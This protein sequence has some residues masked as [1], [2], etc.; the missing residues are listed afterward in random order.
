[1]EPHSA[2]T[3][4][5]FQ[6]LSSG[7]VDDEFWH[8]LY[9]RKLQVQQLSEEAIH[10]VA[11]I[12]PTARRGL[13]ATLHVEAASLSGDCEVEKGKLKVPGT[14]VNFN[15]AARFASKNAREE[16]FRNVVGRIWEDV[17][18]G[19]ALRD[20]SKLSRFL[21]VTFA[22]LKSF[23]FH[24]WFAFPAIKPPENF[25]A[26]KPVPLPQ[27][28]TVTQE[29]VDSCARRTSEL[30]WALHLTDTSQ[31]VEGS[32]SEFHSL[33]EKFGQVYVAYAD[34]SLDQNTAGWTL[35]NLLILMQRWWVQ[36]RVKV[37]SVRYCRGRPDLNSS[38]VLDIELPQ[39][40][41]NFSAE[42]TPVAVGWEKNRA[43]KLLPR[44]VNLSSSMDPSKLAS[45]AVD[46][47]LR[48]MKWRAAPG[49]DI[50]RVARLNCLILGAGTLGCTVARGLVAWGVRN[51]T[52][53]DAG[54]VS[55]S[56]PARQS[57][58]VFHDCLGGGLPK[59]E[60]A[61]THLKEV[62]PGVL[63]TGVEMTIPMPGHRIVKEDVDVTMDSIR[64]LDALV[65]ASDVVFILTDT[66]ESRWLPTLLATTH[67]KITLNSALGFDSFLVMRH[68]PKPSSVSKERLGCYFCN[69]VV[70]PTN[71]TV[72]RT[73]DQQCTVT[74][75][76][77]ASVAGAL[78]VELMASL[79][80]HP[81]GIFAP[82]C[83]PSKER[84]NVMSTVDSSSP[85]GMV[86]H[87]IRGSLHNFVQQSLTGFAFPSCTACSLKVVEE[88]RNRGTEFILD[89]LQN[90]GSLEELTG[91]VEVHAMADAATVEWD[92]DTSDLE[93]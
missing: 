81:E 77:L 64:R 38:L 73:L 56:N 7:V 27:L 82:A 74:R 44:K 22:D 41:S 79:A 4:L 31:F 66:R 28:H 87:S 62:F 83:N 52:L 19:E 15:T 54:R 60:S 51:I 25:M 45:T 57:L 37:I 46:L 14:L 18:N 50:E 2:H 34:P 72:D 76:G 84:M 61:A 88:Y 29:L 21:L 23:H 55:Y 39:I 67:N 17:Q 63:A 20:P 86:P 47:N 91:L 70:A 10:L 30:A 40:S 48:L 89:A 43:G 71:S 49:L 69:D 1:M 6:P 85:L 36:R 3:L 5:Q 53:V 32:L 58:Y 78:A 26:S 11:S 24:Y 8:A 93:Q 65:Q 33:Q 16:V 9:R 12:Q 59:A 35:R 68:G 75:P 92:Y 42:H 90:P 80:N 13:P